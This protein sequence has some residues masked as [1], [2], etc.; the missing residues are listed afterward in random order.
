MWESVTRITDWLVKLASLAVTGPATWIVAGEL[1]IDVTDP[2]LYFAM[3]LSAV[4]LVEGVLLSSWLRLE[5]DV[6]ADSLLKARYG[7]TALAMYV[8]LLV[9]A[10]RHEGPAG[11]VFRVALLA[12]LIGSGWDSYVDTW[13]R[14]TRRVDRSAINSARVKRHR[15]KLAILTERTRASAETDVALREIGLNKSRQLA[16][17]GLQDI[18]LQQETQQGHDVRVQELAEAAPQPALLSNG[19]MPS[20]Y[21]L[22]TEYINAPKQEKVRQRRKKLKTKRKRNPALIRARGIDWL[23]EKYDVGRSTAASDWKAV[24]Q[25]LHQEEQPKSTA[26]GHEPTTTEVLQTRPVQTQSEERG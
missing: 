25:E 7:M 8:A 6:K 26:N 9:I 22:P 21:P 17:L 2:T 3:R 13:K 5:F 14:A 16:W 24:E 15:R 11:L 19:S 20:I 18:E 10:W 23:V 12:A 1:F 4:F